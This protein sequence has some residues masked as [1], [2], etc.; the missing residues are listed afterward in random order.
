MTIMVSLPLGDYENGT[1][2]GVWVPVPA[3]THHALAIIKRC[4]A[5]TPDIWPNVET[6]ID[7]I[8]EMSLNGGASVYKS[9][10]TT[11]PAIP[12]GVTKKNGV[13]YPISS[14]GYWDLSPN[15]G[16]SAFVRATVVVK[17]GPWRSQV[18]FDVD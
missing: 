5:Q 16:D 1:H 14:Q 12:G 4:T 11:A 18:E 10:P 3:G 9:S 7:L 2:V 13:D 8:I 6:E 15:L 17:N